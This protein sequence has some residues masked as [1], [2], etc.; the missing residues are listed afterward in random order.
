MKI[1]DL[2]LCSLRK[3]NN[4]IQNIFSRNIYKLFLKINSFVFYQT[5]RYLHNIIWWK[6]YISKYERNQY[7]YRKSK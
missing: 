4:L 2:K 7:E 6:T 5:I 3:S 1:I